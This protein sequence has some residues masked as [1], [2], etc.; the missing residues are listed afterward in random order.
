MASFSATFSEW[1]WRRVD[2]VRWKWTTSP[3]LPSPIFVILP[4]ILDYKCESIKEHNPDVNSLSKFMSD[5]PLFHIQFNKY[6]VKLVSF[7]LIHAILWI[8][9]HIQIRNGTWFI[10]SL[11]SMN[12]VIFDSLKW[13]SGG[14]RKR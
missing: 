11:Y 5:H 10:I 8:W 9:F 1:E 6:V 12:S 14:A 13:K 3:S 2:A 4:R 7:Q